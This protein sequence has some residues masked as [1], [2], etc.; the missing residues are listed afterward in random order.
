MA[1]P[2]PIDQI[3]P[4]EVPAFSAWLSYGDPPPGFTMQEIDRELG[5]GEARKMYPYAFPKE[6][7][8]R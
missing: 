2:N 5:K 7:D 1:E 4:E 8:A 3:S 6:N